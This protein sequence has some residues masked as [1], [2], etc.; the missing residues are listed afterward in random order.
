[1]RKAF[2]LM[3]MVVA[4]GILAIVMSFAG[5]IFRVSVDSHRL[6]LANAEILQKLR[7]ITEQLDCGFSRAAQGWR[8]PGLLAGGAGQEL[9]RVK[10]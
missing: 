2:T 1:M 5:V 7:A 9:P 3:E 4:L 10:P 6:A 8:G